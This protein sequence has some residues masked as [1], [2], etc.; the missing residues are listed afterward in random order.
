MKLLPSKLTARKHC[1]G[2]QNHATSSRNLFIEGTP[3]HVEIIFPVSSRLESW[4]LIA[5]RTKKI[6]YLIRPRFANL[7]R[8]ASDRSGDEPFQEEGQAIESLGK[9]R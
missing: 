2:Q 8:G 6:L 4:P 5:V 1:V 9:T 7:A 3:L